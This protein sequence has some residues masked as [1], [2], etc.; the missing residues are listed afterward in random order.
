MCRAFGVH[1]FG[2]PCNLPLSFRVSAILPLLL[3]RTPLFPYPT[4]SLPKFP[5]VPL[6]IG[7][8]PFHYKQRSRRANIV[9]AVSFQDF[10]PMWS[11]STDVTDGRTNGRTARRTTYA[12]ARPRSALIALCRKMYVKNSTFTGMQNS[13][14]RTLLSYIG[15]V[16]LVLGLGL[17]CSGLVNTRAVLSL[18]NRAKPCKFRY[19]KSV[20]NFMW[21]LCYRKDDRAMHPL[22]RCPENFRGSLTT[23]T[24]TIPKIFH[25]LL[26]RSTLCPMNVPTKFE[27]RSFTRSWDNRG[28]QKMLA[29]PGYTYPRSFFSNFMDFYSD[30]PCKC[31]RQIWRP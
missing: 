17:E 7:W 14:P 27:L 21:K 10:Q 30:W 15:T 26:F 6:G 22:R 31:T 20:S 4:S 11:Q 29:A 18:G 28:T 1:F 5:H 3:S 25:W 13:K 12:I 9:C 8:S 24:A 2:P 19:V 23:P 16:M